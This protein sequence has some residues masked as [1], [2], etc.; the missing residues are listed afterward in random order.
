MNLNLF[1]QRNI[2]L[3]ALTIFMFSMCMIFNNS[4]LS[5]TT[6]L[7]IFILIP[8]I[9]IITGRFKDNSNSFITSIPALVSI[10]TIPSLYGIGFSS[11]PFVTLSTI[12]ISIFLYNIHKYYSKKLDMKIKNKRELYYNDDNF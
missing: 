12:I 1:F 2:F 9:L 7:V 10:G 11:Q 6:Q 4:P 5:K 3:I 8:F